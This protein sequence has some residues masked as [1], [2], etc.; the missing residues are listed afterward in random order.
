MCFGLRKVTQVPWAVFL[1]LILSFLYA[2]RFFSFSVFLLNIPFFGVSGVLEVQDGQVNSALIPPSLLDA[3]LM[4]EQQIMII[5]IMRVVDARLGFVLCTPLFVCITSYIY[6]YIYKIMLTMIMSSGCM[7]RACFVYVF[8]SCH[9]LDATPKLRHSLGQI[10][11]FS[12]F[13]FSVRGSHFFF[14][15]KLNALISLPGGRTL[16]RSKTFFFSDIV[17]LARIYSEGRKESHKTV[18]SQLSLRRSS[19]VTSKNDIK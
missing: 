11:F 17:L 3:P 4:H 1:D 7:F 14:L 8:V 15:S 18:P 6:I 16:N 9:H 12:F 10:S 19:P 5:M 13:F 2:N